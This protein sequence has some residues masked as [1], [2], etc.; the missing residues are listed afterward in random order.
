[1]VSGVVDENESLDLDLDDLDDLAD[2]VGEPFLEDFFLLVFLGGFGMSG[3]GVAS[4]PLFSG[5]MPY[6]D[7]SRGWS[8]SAKELQ[9]IRGQIYDGSRWISKVL[10]NF[11]NYMYM[12]KFILCD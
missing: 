4:W 7:M 12:I 11:G 8:K 2:A 5:S 10:A 9:K 3:Y 6:G 1:M